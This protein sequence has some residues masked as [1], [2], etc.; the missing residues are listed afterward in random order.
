MEIEIRFRWAYSLVRHRSRFG[1]F[2]D[3]M[4]HL[5]YRRCTSFSMVSSI[6]ISNTRIEFFI[7]YIL[8]PNFILL[9]WHA[10]VLW[11]CSAFVDYWLWRLPGWCPD[12]IYPVRWLLA[13]YAPI[14]LA[15]LCHK[16]QKI[17][18]P[19]S[20]CI[21]RNAKVFVRIHLRCDYVNLRMPSIMPVQQ[22]ALCQ[23][24]WKISKIF[25]LKNPH[26]IFVYSIFTFSFILWRISLVLYKSSG[27]QPKLGAV[28]ADLNNS[29]RLLT[30]LTAL[31]DCKALHYNYLNATRGLCESG[32]LGLLLMLAASF[33]AAILLTIMVWV[34]RMELK[35]SPADFKFFFFSLLI[36]SSGWLTHLDLHPKANRLFTSWRTVVCFTSSTTW[37]SSSTAATA[38]ASQS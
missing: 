24:E 31:V 10:A 15:I 3:F 32:L 17:Y 16:L 29:E 21:T 4:H 18:L 26:N 37:S 1:S 7:T 19:K 23:G 14:Q 20:F 28:T 5:T 12:Y 11:Y 9:L 2:A 25:P 33:S 13:I 22:W 38:T 34:S 35:I 36:F 6:L 30:H 27:L 8:L